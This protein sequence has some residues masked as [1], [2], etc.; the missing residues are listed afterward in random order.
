M[1]SPTPLLA[2]L[3]RDAH[4]L[5]RDIPHLPDPPPESA[6]RYHRLSLRNVRLNF[7]GAHPAKDPIHATIAALQPDDPLQIDKGRWPWKIQTPNG[8]TVGILANN[9]DTRQ[10]TQGR[11]PVAS[12]VLAIAHWTRNKTGLEYQKGLGSDRWEVVIPEMVTLP[13]QA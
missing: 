9:D 7:A 1:A 12:H 3:K 2:D 11:K 10:L 8:Q 6:Y 4:I 5:Q 13:E